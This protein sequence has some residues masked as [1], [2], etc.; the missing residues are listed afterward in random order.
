MTILKTNRGFQKKLWDIP[1][2]FKARKASGTHFAPDRSSGVPVDSVVALVSAP[3]PNL[4]DLMKFSA[5]DA[6]GTLSPPPIQQIV[7]PPVQDY[8]GPIVQKP[9]MTRLMDKMQVIMDVVGTVD[10]SPISDG[11]NAATSI[12]RAF[13]DRS[14]A[15]VHLRNAATSA[16]SMVPVV[17][18]LAKLAKYSSAG[19]A[20]E[21]L[22]ALG[23]AG[24]NGSGGGILGTIA[25]MFGGGGSVFPQQQLE[26]VAPARCLCWVQSD[27]LQLQSVLQ[28][29]MSRVAYVDLAI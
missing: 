27:L 4:S 9:M 10:P 21:E 12:G 16:I 26:R 13:T 18:D 28:S 19:T 29:K 17:G 15:G 7:A 6:E 11:L 22:A 2:Q 5:R 20:G 24:G 3:V 23:G 14:N 8:F 1:E 25:G